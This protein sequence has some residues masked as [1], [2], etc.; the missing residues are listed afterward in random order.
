MTGQGAPARTSKSARRSTKARTPPMSKLPKLPKGTTERLAP[1]FGSFD[2]FD[3]GGGELHVDAPN[4]CA[5]CRANP[6]LATLTRCAH[7]IRA[8]A[9][10]DRQTRQAAE[11]RVATRKSAREAE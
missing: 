9:E 6:C 11:S 4:L 8:A 2:S 10:M 1:S 3:R 5:E 7:C